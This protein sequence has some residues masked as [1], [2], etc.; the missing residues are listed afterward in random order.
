V[1]GWLSRSLLKELVRVTGPPDFG[2]MGSTPHT[3]PGFRDSDLLI[4]PMMGSLVR[5]A[6]AS[7][8][9]VGNVR[10]RRERRAVRGKL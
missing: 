5:P 8:P 4:R 2:S 9:K 7:A 3:H 6:P 10:H 1:L